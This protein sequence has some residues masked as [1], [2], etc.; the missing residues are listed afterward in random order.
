MFEQVQN[1]GDEI[2]DEVK[3]YFIFGIVTS[4]SFIDVMEWWTAREDVFPAHYQMAADYLGTPATSM[5]S[6]RVNSMAGH[7]FTT[8]R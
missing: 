2:G 6:E 5:P 1:V 7:E 3:K 8:A 4:S